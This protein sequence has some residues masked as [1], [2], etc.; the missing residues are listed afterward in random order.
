VQP[1]KA[2]QQLRHCTTRQ[3]LWQDRVA[4]GRTRGWAWSAGWLPARSP[5]PRWGLSELSLPGPVDRTG[6]Q[7]LLTSE[8]ESVVHRQLTRTVTLETNTLQCCARSAKWLMQPAAH[9]CSSG[10]CTDVAPY[11]SSRRGAGNQVGQPRHICS[12]RSEHANQ[13]D[14]QAALLGAPRGGT[15]TVRLKCTAAL[16]HVYACHVLLPVLFTGATLHPFR[17]KTVPDEDGAGA[18]AGP[19]VRPYAA[20]AINSTNRVN[21]RVPAIFL[22]IM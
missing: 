3:R 22:R 7:L 16:R 5:G 2:L 13:A 4:R 11:R 17:H 9:R 14:G 19:N 8:L 1:G 20:A 12:C 6:R 18:G 21:R 15:D 10:I